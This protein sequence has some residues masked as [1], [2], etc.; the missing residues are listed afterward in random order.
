MLVRNKQNKSLRLSMNM[1]SNNKTY[2]RTSQLALKMNH[3][4]T[5]G[6]LINLVPIVV[7]TILSI[8][9]KSL[10]QVKLT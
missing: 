4:R 5:N 2:K 9:K 3:Y 8:P 6:F 10:F 7:Q 1:L